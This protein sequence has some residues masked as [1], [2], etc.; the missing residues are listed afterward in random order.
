L[1]FDSFNDLGVTVDSKLSFSKHCD[2]LAAKCHRIRGCLQRVFRTRD[3]STHLQAFKSYVQPHLDY[4]S[5]VWS[6]HTG[7]DVT[8]VESVL[9]R[10][11]KSILR[12]LE[13]EY[14]ERLK[15]LGVQSLEARRHHKDLHIAHQMF[16]NTSVLNFN[17]FV[18]LTNSVRN[19]LDS[20]YSLRS[21]S[22]IDPVSNVA[23]C[24]KPHQ[25]FYP[26]TRIDCRKYAFCNRIIDCWNNTEYDFVSRLPSGIDYWTDHNCKLHLHIT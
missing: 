15:Q 12:P 2:Q 20:K 7:K 9:R 22:S 23:N 25:I 17:D 21:Y 4:C 8:T 5:T 10:F 24:S 1:N 6:P 3:I 13:L 19:S 11:T 16:R 14:S 18:T 26:D